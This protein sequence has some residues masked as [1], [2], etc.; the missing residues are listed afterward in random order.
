MVVH[1]PESAACTSE[2]AGR[3]LPWREWLGQQDASTSCVLSDSRPTT[4]Q[5]AVNDVCEGQCIK[6][7]DTI[8][9]TSQGVFHDATV[10]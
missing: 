3:R 1:C 9:S 4:I 6:T 7:P 5:H 2:G 8:R 10:A